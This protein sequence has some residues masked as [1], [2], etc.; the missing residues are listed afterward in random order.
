M[1][2]SIEA[3][4]ERGKIR[5]KQRIEREMKA[6]KKAKLEQISLF[7]SRIESIK[8]NKGLLKFRLRK[9]LRKEHRQRCGLK[10]FKKNA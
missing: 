2:E 4:N 10:M 6:L 9:S 1:Y 5:T 3:I 8:R 7:P